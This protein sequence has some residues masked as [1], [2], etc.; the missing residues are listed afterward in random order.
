V[1]V[2]RLPPLDGS[3][4]RKQ[5]AQAARDAIG[6]TLGLTSPGQSPIGEVE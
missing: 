4:D 3:L 5:L 1:T 6:R 2:H